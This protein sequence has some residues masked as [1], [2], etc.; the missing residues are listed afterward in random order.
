MEGGKLS[1]YAFRK[2]AEKNCFSPNWLFWRVE[3][4]P[5]PFYGIGC[6]YIP[7]VKK[8]FSPHPSQTAQCGH[9]GWWRIATIP[10][11]HFTKW[12]WIQDEDFGARWSSDLSPSCHFLV[13]QWQPLWKWGQ[14][15][16]SPRL[17]WGSS[18]IL[19]MIYLWCTFF[20]HL[21]SIP[22]FLLTL[23]LWGPPIVLGTKSPPKSSVREYVTWLS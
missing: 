5:F 20:G 22:S 15:S 14:W 8:L 10:S 7:Q 21:P 11:L 12:I 1:H 3:N 2:N 13:G 17:Q 19:Y 9:L 4:F 18:A 23:S 16:P 6:R